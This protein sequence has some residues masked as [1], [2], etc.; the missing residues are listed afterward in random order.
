[1]IYLYIYTSSVRDSTESVFDCHAT[2]LQHVNHQESRAR[3]ASLSLLLHLR[4]FYLGISISKVCL[5]NHR[6][7]GM[8]LEWNNLEYYVPVLT[9]MQQLFRKLLFNGSMIVF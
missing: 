9:K 2:K 7:N 6:I 4:R 8:E 5:V 1:M 3:K